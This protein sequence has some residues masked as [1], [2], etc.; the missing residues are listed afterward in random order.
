MQINGVLTRMLSI[1]H[2]S[3]FPN[4][5]EINRNHLKRAVLL[6]IAAFVFTS[7]GSQNKSGVS[8]SPSNASDRY[9]VSNEHI[10]PIL[11]SYMS[12]EKMLKR[13]RRLYKISTENLDPSKDKNIETIKIKTQ[14]T[15]PHPLSRFVTRK[16]VTMTLDCISGQGLSIESK[17][18]DFD[19]SSGEN[20]FTAFI[21]FDY[22]L[23]N[24]FSIFAQ[25]KSSPSAQHLG[26]RGTHP[27][28]RRFSLHPTQF[29][30]KQ[31]ENAI[32]FSFETALKVQ[33]NVGANAFCT[34]PSQTY[35]FIISLRPQSEG[36]SN[37][38]PQFSVELKKFGSQ[39][40]QNPNIESIEC[41][42][43]EL[44]FKYDEKI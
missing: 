25:Q 2:Q 23:D 41:E 16:D 26:Q 1:D 28:N 4:R 7:C 18:N 36:E 42:K 19:I 43:S 5:I 21:N 31:L 44:N 11:C 15:L 37:L 39:I 40:S 9:L 24:T 27:I 38:R 32:S 33:S 29:N 22:N 14:Q 35:E 6:I 17:E 13:G 10:I 34:L 8:S 20:L 12:Q 3:L 30:F